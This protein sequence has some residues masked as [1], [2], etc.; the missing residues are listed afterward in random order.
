MTFHVKKLFRFPEF[1]KDAD[2]KKNRSVASE[3]LRT[4][5]EENRTSVSAE[6]K[7]LENTTKSKLGYL[8]YEITL[9][10]YSIN[11]MKFY[12]NM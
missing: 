9:K 7:K 1:R 3:K 8:K 6:E 5:L 11:C 12:D 2:T 10:R 4:S